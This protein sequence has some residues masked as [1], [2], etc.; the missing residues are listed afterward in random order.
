MIIKGSSHSGKKLGD[1]LT[2][3]KNERAKVLGIRGDLPRDLPE[4]LDDWRST[5]HG[6]QCKKP[7]YHAQLN[8]DRALSPEEWQKAVEIFEKEMGFENQPRAMVLHEYK[9]REHMHLVYS[10]I[11]ENGRAISDSWNY[12]S[13]EK[14]AR[15]IERE[16][17]LEKTQGV[18]IDRDGE[19][20][21]RTPSHD[22]IQQ[23]E[24]TKIDPHHVKTEVSAL[25]QSAD[26]GRAFVAG[27]EDAGYT[28]AQGDKR[29]L[30]ILDQAGGVHSLSRVAGV[31]VAALRERLKDFPLEELPSVSDTRTERQTVAKEEK[32]AHYT[33]CRRDSGSEEETALSCMVSVA[34]AMTKARDETT[35][36][37]WRER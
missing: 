3:D 11:D 31:K 26:G 35:R 20:P 21:E 22:S 15:E 7:L 28:L 17:G 8:P 32:G 16:L 10:R 13:H 29:G 4:L 24:R 33:S 25:Y 19:R 18:F 14:A 30:V 5:A 6:S 1:Y 37:L 23:G 34:P 9:G 12:V 36:R 2:Q 27:L